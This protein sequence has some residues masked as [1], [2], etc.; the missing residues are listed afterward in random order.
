MRP[1]VGLRRPENR[2]DR[3]R[4][5]E[6]GR[7]R[8]SPHRGFAVN[9]LHALSSTAA[10]RLLAAAIL[11]PPLGAAC[12][13][14][15]EGDAGGGGGSC[16]VRGAA[17]IDAAAVEAVELATLDTGAMNTLDLIDDHGLMSPRMHALAAADCGAAGVVY[18]DGDSGALHFRAW[19]TDASVAVGSSA[20][21][22]ALF[23]VDCAPEVLVWES[24]T[25][26]VAYA[27]DATEPSA[28]AAQTVLAADDAVFDGGSPMV[29]AAESGAGGDAVFLR[30]GEDPDRVDTIVAVRRVNDDWQA[31][32]HAAPTGTTETVDAAL[33]ANGGV[34]LAYRKTA[35]PCDPCEVTLFHALLGDPMVESELQHGVWGPPRD[36]FSR[37]GEL[38][39]AP[40][41]RVLFAGYYEEHV[42]T[43]STTQSQLRVYGASASGSYCGD[44][45]ATRSDGYAGSD[46]TDYTGA[47]SAMA[48]DGEGRVYVAFTDESTWHS[49]GMENRIQGQLRLAVGTAGGWDVTTLVEQPGQTEV[50]Q[51]L[52]GLN[53]VQVAVSPDGSGVFVAYAT[54]EWDTN[55]IY[56]EMDVGAVL[57]PTLAKVR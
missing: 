49:S 50:S 35:F 31:G 57:V 8:R 26:L 17:E 11:L 44:R 47:L 15:V 9:A 55:S 43:G 38:L 29:F 48:I 42:A 5:S 27:G 16:D 36:K 30:Q 20:S 3:R 33:D 56:N 4:V 37:E 45:I 28:F 6:Y 10:T 51:P 40:D 34:H 24:G 52:Q 39:V 41:G 7:G 14:S 21:K 13:D 54:F 22:A 25:G 32:R 2:A 1:P 23:Y 19:G 18:F 53:Q 12:G 46:G